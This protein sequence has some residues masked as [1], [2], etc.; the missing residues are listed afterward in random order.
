[1]LE[2][3]RSAEPSPEV[4][5]Q[6]RASLEGALAEFRLEAAKVAVLQ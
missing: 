6:F 5:K 3:F 2:P 1:V 4:V